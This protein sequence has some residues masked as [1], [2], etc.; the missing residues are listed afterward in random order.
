MSE[1]QAY[2]QALSYLLSFVDFSLTHQEQIAPE[3]FELERMIVLLGKMGNPQTAYPVIHIAGTKGK[4]SVAAHCGAALRAGGYKTG[5]YTSP[6]LHD[7][8]ERIQVNGEMIPE[9][10]FVSLVDK[11]KPAIASSLLD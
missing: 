6:H 11:L 4:G 3:R 9:S 8:R 2:Q 10:E 7:F 1:N 5:L